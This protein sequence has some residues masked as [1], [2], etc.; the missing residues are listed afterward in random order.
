MRFTVFTPTYNRKYIIENLYHSLQRQTFKDFE[1]LVVDDGSTDGT[2]ESFRAIQ[3][4]CTAFPIRYI[5]TENGGKHRA[6]NIGVREASGELFFIV[7]SDDYLTDDALETADQVEKSIPNEEKD[8]FAGVCGQ[9]GHDT[10]SAIGKTFTGK[11]LDITMLERPS[12]GIWG[13]KAE[14][15]YTKV[16]KRYPFPEFNGEKFVTECVVWDRIAFDG[17]KLRFYNEIAVICKYLPDGLTSQGNDLL[18]KNPKGYSLYLYQCSKFGKISGLGKWNQFADYFY[19]L[20]KEYSYIEI[21]KDLH[22]APLTFALRI[23]GLRIIY[24]LYQ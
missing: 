23:L 11:A 8:K 3:Q 17:L 15:F 1:W 14:I 6:I 7:D 12:Y 5:K 9:R 20:R 21:C 13:D 24:R 4:E 18:F 22:V 2:E 10:N 19:K 16:L